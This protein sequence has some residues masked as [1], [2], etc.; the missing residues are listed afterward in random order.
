MIAA[1]FC[2]VIKKN[3]AGG[4]NDTVQIGLQDS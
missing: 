3:L 2:G 4:K 1:F